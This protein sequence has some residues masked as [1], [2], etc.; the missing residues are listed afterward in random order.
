MRALADREKK[1]NPS[2]HGRAFCHIFEGL[3]GLSRIPAALAGNPRTGAP[4]EEK[5]KVFRGWAV[6]RSR[7]PQQYLQ[8]RRS[9]TAQG[10][11]AGYA[12][13]YSAQMMAF[14]QHRVGSGVSER[15]SSRVGILC[16]SETHVAIPEVSV[17]AIG[18]AV[19]LL[20]YQMRESYSR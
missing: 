4:K 7:R 5:K 14:F 9:D 2:F 15:H 12:R 16:L 18:V 20:K 8:T 1:L 6:P 13:L 17:L 19:S 3:H 10:A 11:L